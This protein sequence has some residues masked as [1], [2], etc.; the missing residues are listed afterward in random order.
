MHVEESE[1]FSRYWVTSETMR[2]RRYLV[3]L[4]DR[5]DDAGRAHGRCDC[6]FYQTTVTGNYNKDQTHRPYRL[7]W[8]GQVAEFVTECKHIK[9]AREHFH[10]TVTMPMLAIMRDG[11]E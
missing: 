10:L 11:V 3:D 4:T 5:I 8:S 9:A 2:D 1:G 6:T 7:T